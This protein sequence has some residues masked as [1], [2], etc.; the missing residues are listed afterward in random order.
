MQKPDSKT[1]AALLLSGLL[2]PSLTL[3]QHDQHSGQE[4]D[5][6]AHTM[7]HGGHAMDHGADDAET[8][9]GPTEAGQDAFA[10]IQEVVAI[11]EA[12]P[13]T[14]WSRVDIDVLRDHLIDMHLVTLYAGVEKEAVDGG[15]RYQVTGEGETVGA[16]QRMVTAHARQMSGDTDWTATT[17]ERDDGVELT[18]TADATAEVAKI[19]GLGFA[20]FMALGDHH[21]PHHLMMATG[22]S[23]HQH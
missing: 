4:T 21:Q 15:A 16:I 20:G 5:H 1:L 6:S 17:T 23:V 3:A 2:A 11:L 10:A 14:D 8:A 19:R 22:G 18:V 13:D 12:D 7:D 9:T